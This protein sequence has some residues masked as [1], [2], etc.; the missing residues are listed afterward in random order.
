MDPLIGERVNSVTWNAVLNHALGERLRHETT[1][2]NIGEAMMIICEI[3]PCPSSPI[4][5]LHHLLEFSIDAEGV[6]KVTLS[7][8]QRALGRLRRCRTDN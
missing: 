3:M 5:L 4:M 8:L 7:E 6:T 1:V 2:E